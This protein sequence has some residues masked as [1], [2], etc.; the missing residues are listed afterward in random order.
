MHLD[1]AALGHDWSDVIEVHDEV[2]GE[3]YWWGE[4]NYVRLD[5]FVPSRPTSSTVRTAP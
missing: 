2:T 4:H 5:P 1:M 3:S